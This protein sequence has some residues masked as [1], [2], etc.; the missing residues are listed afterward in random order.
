MIGE[1]TTVSPPRRKAKRGLQPCYCPFPAI[2]LSFGLNG[3]HQ[4]AGSP[5]KALAARS[6]VKDEAGERLAGITGDGPIQA[7]KGKGRRT[8]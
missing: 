5:T 6:E 1:P 2:P 4:R 3:V 7:T 8:T